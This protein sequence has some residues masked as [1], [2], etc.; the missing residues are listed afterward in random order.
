LIEFED[1]PFKIAKLGPVYLAKTLETFPDLAHYSSL[2]K[3]TL[4][5]RILQKSKAFYTTLKFKTLASQLQFYGSWE[6]IE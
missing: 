2:I 1:S 5:V 4:A 3:R 6:M